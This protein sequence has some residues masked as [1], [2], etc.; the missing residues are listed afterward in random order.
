[1][2]LRKPIPQELRD[3]MSMKPFYKKCCIANDNCFGRIEWHHHKTHKGTRLNKEWCIL[4]VCQHHH[5][6]A[7]IRNTRE[8]MDWVALNRASDQ[9]LKEISQAEDYIKTREML[10]RIYGEYKRV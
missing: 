7:N 8:R 10:N 3:S 2:A 4:P 1:M 6:R 5:G 9:E